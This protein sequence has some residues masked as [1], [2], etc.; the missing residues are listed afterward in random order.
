MNA[1]SRRYDIG[2]ENQI[3]IYGIVNQIDTAL[4][5]K[6]QMDTISTHEN[7]VDTISQIKS[8]RYR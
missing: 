2:N 8:I 1:K 6:N 7:Q 5:M 4:I 3:D